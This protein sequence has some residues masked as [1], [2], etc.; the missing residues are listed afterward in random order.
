M[1]IPYLIFAVCMV[2]CGG[3]AYYLGRRLGIEATIQYLIDQGVLEEADEDDY[4]D[5]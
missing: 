1:F 3:H 2:G 5:G 4:Y